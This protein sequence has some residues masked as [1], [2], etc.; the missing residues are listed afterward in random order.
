MST[1]TIIAGSQALG[2]GAG[3]VSAIGQASALRAQGNAAERNLRE[4]ARLERVRAEE[5]LDIGEQEALRQ[6]GRIRQVLG[7]QQAALAAQGIQVDTGSA[8]DLQ[9]DAQRF[10]AA[11]QL[12]IRFNAIRESF[13]LQSRAIALETQGRLEG[14]SGRTQARQTILGAGA[15]FGRQLGQTGVLAQRG[16]FDAPGNQAA[17]RAPNPTRNG[18]SAFRFSTGPRPTGSTTFQ[19]SSR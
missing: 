15:Q 2:A 10:G 13:G 4:A 8:L 16:F 5:A 18:G 7:A 3:V 17:N 6:S 14:I 1:G 11:D 9:A 19:F 12:T